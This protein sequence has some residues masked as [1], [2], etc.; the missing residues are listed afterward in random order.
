[1]HAP[2]YDDVMDVI[3]VAACKQLGN[4]K[5]MGLIVP[6]RPPHY[7]CLDVY[8][9][10]KKK[11]PWLNYMK[12]I[13][14]L[15]FKLF[16]EL[17]ILGFAQILEHSCSIALLPFTIILNFK[18]SILLPPPP[19][20]EFMFCVDKPSIVLLLPSVLLDLDKEA[21]HNP[22]RVMEGECWRWK[23]NN[24]LQSGATFFGKYIQKINKP[25][26]KISLF[27]LYFSYSS[28]GHVSLSYSSRVHN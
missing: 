19:L 3:R 23:D 18:G 15:S 10:W 6:P 7:S 22:R 24:S 8:K 13:F 20:V 27:P 4:L 16:K 21:L 1:M 28:L 12:L 5:N 25:L 11:N 14:C 26:S 17:A 9:N 2:W